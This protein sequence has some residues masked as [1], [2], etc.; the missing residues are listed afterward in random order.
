[1]Y[2]ICVHI[3]VCMW[4]CI[5]HKC[6]WNSTRT[7]LS[8]INIHLF[9]PPSY[10][11]PVPGCTRTLIFLLFDKFYSHQSQTL[12]TILLHTAG[13]WIVLLSRSILL[14]PPW[15]LGPA[16]PIPNSCWA[17][18]LVATNWSEMYTAAKTKS[19]ISTPHHTT[20]HHNE[21]T[22]KNTTTPPNLQCSLR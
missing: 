16:P 7:V 3:H 12:S 19:A 1:M 22:H 18:T 5:C 6:T 8:V 2:V 11:I 14:C 10:L 20:T 21:P 13:H 15:F 4:V 9:A 17:N